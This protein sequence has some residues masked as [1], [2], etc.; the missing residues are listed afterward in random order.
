M[1]ISTDEN[2]FKTIM[3]V[4]KILRRSSY[5]E[6][7]FMK[8]V[9]KFVTDLEVFHDVEDVGN[10]DP[11]DFK[12]EMIARHFGVGE[13]HKFENGNYGNGKYCNGKNMKSTNNKRFVKIPFN[14]ILYRK[15]RN[16]AEK[17]NLNVKLAPQSIMKNGHWTFSN[18]KDKKDFSNIKHG[19]YSTKCMNCSF[20]KTFRTTNLDVRRTLMHQFNRKDSIIMEHMKE[21]NGHIIPFSVFGFKSYS[22]NYMIFK[23]LIKK[24]QNL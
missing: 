23:L 2:V 24:L 18:A 3:N 20:E 8:Y 17:Y 7:F 15:S 21:N 22:N 9:A 11:I 10:P 14:K 6:N 5:P 1:K 13:Y 4:K 16:L 19:L 12:Q